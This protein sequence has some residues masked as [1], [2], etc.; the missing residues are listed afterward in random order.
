MTTYMTTSTRTQSCIAPTYSAGADYVA[1]YLTRTGRD[2][3][4]L[5][6]NRALRFRRGSL[7]KWS[8]S[9]AERGI[10]RVGPCS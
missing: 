9:W 7:L 1:S 4:F 10:V 2:L 3:Y 6:S 8:R 5:T